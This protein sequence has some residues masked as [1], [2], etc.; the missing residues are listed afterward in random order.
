MTG[1]LKGE[2][3]KSKNTIKYSLI[4]ILIVAALAI[5]GVVYYYNKNFSGDLILSN[6]VWGTFGDFFG[7]IL[8]PILSFLAL[9]ALFFTIILQ[10]EELEETRKELNQSRQ[11]AEKQKNF[12]ERQAQLDD[13][14]RLIESSFNNLSSL[15]LRDTSSAE[16]WSNA[17]YIL[18]SLYGMINKYEE[19]NDGN[20]QFLATYFRKSC[21]PYIAGFDKSGIPDSCRAGKIPGISIELYGKL[22]GYFYSAFFT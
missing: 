19:L 10:S 2:F 15:R 6:E 12:F 4:V 7:G 14:R 1:I 5:G 20:D 18:D 11:I 3:L 17:I 13:L 8:N 21:A 16:E 22:K 9:I